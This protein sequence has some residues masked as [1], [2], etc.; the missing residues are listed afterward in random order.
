MIHAMGKCLGGVNTKA[1]IVYYI[2][3]Y[4]SKKWLCSNPSVKRISLIYFL[5]DFLQAFLHEKSF[6]RVVVVFGNKNGWL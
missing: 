3:P 5:T 6:Q 1:K 2:F 4:L